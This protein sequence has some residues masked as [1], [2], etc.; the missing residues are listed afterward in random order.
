M[1]PGVW[2]ERESRDDQTLRRC[3]DAITEDEVFQTALEVLNAN[4]T[5][6]SDTTTESLFYTRS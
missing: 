2:P 4:V 1:S 3:L 6:S 5:S